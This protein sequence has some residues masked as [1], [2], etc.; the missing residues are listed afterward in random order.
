MPPPTVCSPHSLPFGTVTL[1][2]LSEANITAAN[3]RQTCMPTDGTWWCIEPTHL[4]LQPKRTRSDPGKF[5]IPGRANACMSVQRPRPSAFALYAKAE[6]G[7]AKA[8]ISPKTMGGLWQGLSK[9]E[10]LPFE[11]EVQ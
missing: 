2:Q 11:Q 9:A 4:R 8:I 6:R 5:P 3:V 1:F 7:T 10:K